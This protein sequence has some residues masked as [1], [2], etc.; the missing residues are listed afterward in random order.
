T[1]LDI[2]FQQRFSDTAV[3]AGM[4]IAIYGRCGED[5]RPLNE[6]LVLQ[7]AAEHRNGRYNVPICKPIGT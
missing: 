7:P 1:Q 3:A 2:H 4:D 6:L 5:V